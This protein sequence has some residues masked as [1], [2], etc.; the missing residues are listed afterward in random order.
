MANFVK[1]IVDRDLIARFRAHHGNAMEV[2][3]VQE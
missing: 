2:L 3:L 1:A